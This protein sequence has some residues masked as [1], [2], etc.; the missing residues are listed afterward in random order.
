MVTGDQLAIAKETGRRLGLGDHM[1]P[2]KGLKDGSAPGGKHASLDEMILNADCFADVFPEHKYK[3]VKCL[4][5]LGHLCAMTGDSANDAPALSRANVGI[6]VEGATDAARGAADIVLTE[7]G[8]ST[9]IAHAI[10]G[11]HAA[12]QRMR[13]YAI[14]ACA[15]TIRIVVC[16]AI[17]AFAYKFD[18]PP[19]IVLIIALPTDGIIMTFSVDR[20]FPSM[21]PDSWDLAEIFAYAV[22]YGIYLTTSTVALVTII[23]NTTSFQDK[24]GVSL[25][26]PH[27]VPVDHNDYQL[28]MIVYLQVLQLVSS[29]ISPR[30]LFS[31]SPL[32]KPQPTRTRK[33]KPIVERTMVTRRTNAGRNPMELEVPTSEDEQVKPAVKRK[34]KVKKS[35]AEEEDIERNR[36]AA[37]LTAGKLEAEMVRQANINESTP[38]VLSTARASRPRSPSYVAPDPSSPHMPASS[39][40]PASQHAP[41]SSPSPV[42]SSSPAPA[43]ASFKRAAALK[44][45]LSTS[46]DEGE[47]AKP[48]TKKVKPTAVGKKQPSYVRS[49]KS[50]QSR[51][52]CEDMDVDQDDMED[53]QFNTKKGK[54][55]PAKANSGRGNGRVKK[56]TQDGAVEETGG[57]FEDVDEE[58]IV[59]KKARP[60]R[61]QVESIRSSHLATR[62][63]YEGEDD[64]DMNMVQ[65]DAPDIWQTDYGYQEPDVKK[66]RNQKPG[67]PAKKPVPNDNLF[68]R[69]ASV[70]ANRGRAVK[71]EDEDVSDSEVE[72][73]ESTLP[74]TK[75]DRKS[76]QNPKQSR[77]FNLTISSGSRQ[78]WQGMKKIQIVKDRDSLT[79]KPNIKT[80]NKSK[81][82]T[83]L[84]KVSTNRIVIYPSDPNPKDQNR[85]EVMKPDR[86][87]YSHALLL[88]M[89]TLD[90]MTLFFFSLSESYQEA[91][92]SDGTD[93]IYDWSATV[94]LGRLKLD[95]GTASNATTPTLTSGTSKLTNASLTSSKLRATRNNKVKI[96]VI[97]EDDT[98]GYSDGAISEKDER[99]GGER[100]LAVKSPPKGRGKRPTSNAL[101][102]VKLSS[103]LDQRCMVAPSASQGIKPGSSAPAIK[104]LTVKTEELDVKAVVVKPKSTSKSTNADL[105]VDWVKHGLWRN[106]INCTIRH[107]ATTNEVFTVKDRTMIHTLVTVCSHTY[108]VPVDKMKIS[109]TDAAFR[110]AG[111]RL[112]DS[113][114]TILGSAAV[115]ILTAFF[116]SDIQFKSDK[117]RQKFASSLYLHHRYLYKHAGQDTS[118]FKGLFFGPF[119]IQTFAAHLNIIS[120]SRDVLELYIDPEDP[121]AIPTVPMPRGALALCGAAVMRA[122]ALYAIGG[123]TIKGMAD[124]KAKG[125]D[126]RPIYPALIPPISESEKK[127]KAFRPSAFSAKGWEHPTLLF[128]QLATDKIDD[129]SMLDIISQ[130]KEI[131]KA[132]RRNA[133][134]LGSDFDPDDSI[135]QLGNGTDASSDVEM[136]GLSGSRGQHDD[137][138]DDNYDDQISAS[139]DE[140]EDDQAGYDDNRGEFEDGPDDFGVSRRR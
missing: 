37:L 33:D 12:F 125:K 105:P 21:T 61:D 83:V 27:G 89:F 121:E 82:N 70:V 102:K 119:V 91:D 104:T 98:Y 122:V 51:D 79:T 118:K 41:A 110:L 64:F 23:T 114:R 66:S 71:L 56:T 26:T 85:N 107:I 2:A 8:L 120:G 44:S 36:T 13:N 35:P 81:S 63:V 14:Y 103:A 19:V 43:P 62:S 9:T 136:D 39:P 57:F 86:Y 108:G 95:P 4:Q 111:Y 50:Q 135:L 55:A 116:D 52:S 24:F 18:F 10:R 94:P 11:S 124:A 92:S 3:I 53:V 127:R 69:K 40:A 32:I 76:A 123:I 47:G 15:V 49:A 88:P 45:V 80:A 113:W 137:V 129:D 140:D 117:S 68:Q 73:V 131:S 132:S 20:V 106:V 6:A 54:R 34:R 22:A 58:M 30:T 138:N 134:E 75:T 65:D 84:T 67:P 87:V 7:L 133:R 112:A 1:Y 46:D 59:K 74:N 96:R 60:L 72:I 100:A 78:S 38:R 90:R 109:T 77:T 93:K 31:S 16:F 130:A 128:Y 115:A 97:P 42:F 126:K 29:H 48:P 99:L 101:V 139:Q 17:L 28:R 5:G 25:N